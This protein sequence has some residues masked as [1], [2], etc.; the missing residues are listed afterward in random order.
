MVGWLVTST[1]SAA[2]YAV[3]PLVGAALMLAGFGSG[4]MLTLKACTV[5]NSGLWLT[6]EGLSGA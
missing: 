5:I 1:A 2:G 4:S 3:I 6:Y